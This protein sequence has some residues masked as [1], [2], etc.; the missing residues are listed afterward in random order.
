MVPAAIR[1][2]ALV[3]ALAGAAP[4]ASQAAPA[5]TTPA[6]GASQTS[7]S[8]DF[9][10]TAT[11][12]GDPQ[13]N[14]VDLTIRGKTA[15]GEDYMSG[16]G[17]DVAPDG[18]WALPDAMIAFDGDYRAVAC[19]PDAAG[20]CSAAR[21]FHIGPPP[22]PGP[23]VALSAPGHLPVL[24]LMKGRLRPTLACKFACEYRGK[25]TIGPDDARRVAL[26]SF[27]R[28]AKLMT[29]DGNVSGGDSA[30]LLGGLARDSSY[31]P[32]AFGFPVARAL[33]AKLTLHVSTPDGP[34]TI[35]RRIRLG[36]PRQTRD[37]GGRGI[38]GLITGITGP[39]RAHLDRKTERFVVH[40]SLRVHNT[41]AKAYY[42]DMAVH[43]PGE[44]FS[45]GGYVFIGL[46]TT[47]KP[48]DVAMRH[49]FGAAKARRLAPLAAQISVHL[50][51]KHGNWPEDAAFRNFTLVK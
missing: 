34:K 49:G 28:G 48:V 27:G 5:I 26:L 22:K 30:K 29:F 9:A 23:N 50:A 20:Q 43:T 37:R 10:G 18:T 47:R 7:H 17:A 25:L 11:A 24:A 32:Q 12:T 38:H 16:Y 21:H 1:L 2:A 45:G 39:Q 8:V 51:P 15:D 19:Q 33:H 44:H 41:A 42:L 40:L 14:R 36:W 46:R 6:E 3:L 35:V 4:A 31:L 13:A